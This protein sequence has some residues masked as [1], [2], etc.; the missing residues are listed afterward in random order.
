MSINKILLFGSTGMLGSYIYSYFSSIVSDIIIIPVQYRFTRDT[1]ND[2][3]PV[4]IQAGIDDECCIINCIGLIPQRK[5]SDAS[6]LDYFL[7]NGVFPHLLWTICKKYKARMI[8]PATDCVFSGSMG[9]YTEDNY[10]D[11]IN[12]YGMSKSLGEPSEATV[13]RTSIIG[14]ELYNKKSFL[15][16]VLSGQTEIDGWKNHLWNGITCLEYCKIIDTIIR[17]NIFWK[18]V[19]HVY[20]PTSVSKYELAKIIANVFQC[21]TNIIGIDAEKKID[22]TLASQ[23]PPLFDIPELSQQIQELT[24]FTH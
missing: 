2:I 11:E 6:D 12:P 9:Q 3:E 20:S 5:S 18:G 1:F 13:I 19:R 22:K 16:W 15:E 14:R 4:L 21:N 24:L 8:Q 10:H 17:K 7:V 23:Y